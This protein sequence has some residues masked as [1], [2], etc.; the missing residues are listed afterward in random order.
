MNSKASLRF[1]NSGMLH[2]KSNSLIQSYPTPSR[3]EERKTKKEISRKLQSKQARSH[4]R[5]L[6]RIR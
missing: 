3:R 1:L 2:L 6:E 4:V 5:S